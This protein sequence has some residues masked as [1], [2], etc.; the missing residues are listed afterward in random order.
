M[1]TWDAYLKTVTEEV[2]IDPNVDREACER[3]FASEREK[4]GERSPKDQ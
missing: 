3:A 1:I 4:A 2:K